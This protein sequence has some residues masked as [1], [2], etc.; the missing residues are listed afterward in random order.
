MN[1]IDFIVRTPTP[2]LQSD[3]LERSHGLREFR[4]FLSVAHTGNFGRSA[5]ELNVS[6]PAISQQVRRLEENLGTQL[7]VRS[8][9]TVTLTQAGIRLRDRLDTVMQLINSPLDDEPATELAPDTVSLAIPAEAGA[10]LIPPLAEEFRAR[11]PHVTL[12]I[13]EGSGADL[14]EWLLHRRVDIAILQDAPPHAELAITPVVTETL[15]VVASVRSTLAEDYRP[16]RLRELADEKLILPARQHWIRRRVAAA[17]HQYGVRLNP[18]L[19]VNSVPLTKAM[20][21]QGLGCSI[22][23]YTAVHEE[24]SRGAL[25]FRP[26]THPSLFST[27]SVA[28][29]RAASAPIVADFARIACEA[30]ATLADSEAWPGVQIV[31]SNSRP[32]ASAPVM[33]P[34][35]SRSYA[36][37]ESISSVI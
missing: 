16:L 10:Q 1:A 37:M 32:E 27:R 33:V 2:S 21:R 25:A 34:E 30:M 31:K 11:W 35:S 28:I 29:H 14:E 6:Q 13:R 4:Y 24:V 7:L 36:T 22:L 5:R 23:P 9:R 26:I 20:V 8:G 12:D 3:A 15:G 18:I 17:E 19:Q